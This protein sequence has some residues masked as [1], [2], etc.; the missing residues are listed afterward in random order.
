[1]HDEE[2]NDQDAREMARIVDRYE[3]MV[4]A[5]VPAFFDLM[6]LEALIEHFLQH[7][8]HKKAQ[9]VLKFASGLYP[10]SLSLQLREVQLMAGTGNVK[11]AIPRLRNLLAFEPTNDEIHLTLATL[12]SQLDQHQDAIHH[13]RQALDLGDANFR[14][15]LFIDIALEYENIGHWEHAAEV[16]REALLEDPENETA[17]HELGFCFESMGRVDEAIQVFEVFV[18]QHPYSCAGWYNLGNSHQR[19]GKFEKAIE[20]Y[21]FS[22]VIDEGFSPAL[23]QKA[24]ALTMLEDYLQALECYRESILLDA[25]QANI[26]TLMGECK[27][28]MDELSE[29]ED[30][31]HCALELDGDFADA[32]VGLGV[33][34]EM[35]KDWTGSLKHFEKAMELEP[36]NVE[37][38]ILLGGILKKIGMHDEAGLIYGNALRLEPENLEVYLEAA[39]NLQCDERFEEALSLMESVPPRSVFDPIVVCRTFVS[40]YS[41]GRTKKAYSL[42]DEALDRIPDLCQTL[43]GIFPGIAQ[44]AEF[45]LRVLN[46]PKKP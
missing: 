40:L 30:Y 29:A 18:D 23:L 25:P 12:Y 22:L 16:L 9:H 11:L 21:E 20:A 33:V 32:H 1:M 6:E 24:A 46:A 31:Y 39:D 38:H 26:Y 10:E 19:Q 42:L 43:I 13:Y 5:D 7:G 17:L 4:T 36:M 45:S 35:R 28:R 14:G 34:A 27:E 15:D 44:D 8:R 3:A 41:L 2:L 37:Y